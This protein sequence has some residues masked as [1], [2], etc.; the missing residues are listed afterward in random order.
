MILF[1]VDHAQFFIGV[2]FFYV[3][4]YVICL[5]TFEVVW[6]TRN[7][8]LASEGWSDITNMAPFFV[9]D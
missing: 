3:D 1:M 9:S 7:Q 6:Y 4:H 8:I 5:H 2:S